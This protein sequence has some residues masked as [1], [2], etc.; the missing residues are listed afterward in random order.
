MC[1]E[2]AEDIDHSFFTAESPQAAG[3]DFFRLQILAGRYHPP[4]K[5]LSP[6]GEGLQ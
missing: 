2:D 6:Q 3:I 4:F 1:L 5:S